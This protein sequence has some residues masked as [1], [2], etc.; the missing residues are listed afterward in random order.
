LNA[1]AGAA[2]QV[3]DDAL[4]E[5]DRPGPTLAAPASAMFR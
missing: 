1:P 3:R 2:E 5:R 4:R